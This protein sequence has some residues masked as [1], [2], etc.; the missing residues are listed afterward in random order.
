ML[1]LGLFIV[2]NRFLHGFASGNMEGYLRISSKCKLATVGEERT[3]KSGSG[4]A[5]ISGSSRTGI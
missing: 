3:A 2:L 4:E 5:D 1:H